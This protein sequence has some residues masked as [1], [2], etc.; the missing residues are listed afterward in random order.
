[1]TTT[2]FDVG[3][4]FAG[5]R[6]EEEIGRG[7]MG[8]V[9]RATE[10]SLER[11]VAL[12]LIT[13]ELA[14][15][16]DFRKR[17][18]RE[19]RIAAS[20]D[21]PHVLPVFAAGEADGQLYLAMRYVEGED[22]KTLLGREGVLS[23][24]HA[25]RI[26]SQIAEALD[27]AHRRGL[28]HRDLKPANVLLDTSGEAYLS[29]F[30]LTKQVGS[31]S[32]ETGRLVGTL[33]YLAP[34]QIRGEEVDARSDEYALACCFY[35]CLAGRAP[36][37]RPT[38]AELLWAHL[39][40][41]P[42]ALPGHPELDP[43][44]AR[45]L[46]KEKDERYESASAFCDAAG[47]ALGVE[48][49]RVRR[50]R[51]LLR[52]S[53]LLVAAGLLVLV[54]AAAA[55]GVEVTTGS[56]SPKP[57]GNAVAAI[58]VANGDVSSYTA[59]GATPSNVVTGG[60][61][62]WVLNADDRTISR[63]D[64]RTRRIVKT[65]ATGGVPTDLA[66]E[67][68]SL[69]VGNGSVASVGLASQGYTSSVVRIDPETYRVS[70]TVTLPYDHSVDPAYT[71]PL[72]RLSAYRGSVWAISPDQTVLR[73]DA[74]TARVVERVPV[75]F[76]NTIAAGKEGVWVTRNAS[77]VTRIDPRTGRVSQTIS[78][79]AAGFAG[80]AVGGGSVWAADPEDGTVW[81]IE[82]GPHPTTRTI[83]V[84]PGVT[85]IAFTE[86][87]VWAANFIEETVSHIDPR[88]NTVTS[89]TPVAGT[90]LGIAADR[91]VV[92][93]STAGARAGV[94]PAS[95]CGKVESGGKTPDLLIAS[96]FPLQG[97]GQHHVS[98]S[99]ADAIRFALR[100][101]GY[102]VGEYVVG[103]QSCDDST[104]QSVGSDYF[105]CASNAK[106]YSRTTQLVGLIGPYNSYCAEVQLPILNRA[107]S[108]SVP[109]ISSSNTDPGLTRAGPGVPRGEPESFYPT[110]VRNYLR[111]VPGD[112]LAGA[113]DAVF[114]K[115]LRLRKVYVLR[116][117]YVGYSSGFT[118]AARRIGLP[119][120]D[121]AVWAPQGGNA[122]QRRRQASI[123]SALARRVARSGADGV[124]LG[125]LGFNGGYAF[126]RALR[127]EV[128][129]KFPIIVTDAFFPVPQIMRDAGRPAALN[130]YVSFP[131]LGTLSP[132]G[133]R[134]WREFTMSEPGG[135][136]PNGTYAPQTLQAAELML[137]AIAR[138]DGTRASVLGEL[139]KLRAPDG[140]LG[141]YRFDANGDVTP[142]H[143]TIFK[144]TGRTP[145]SANL[146]S[147]FQGSVPVR[148]VSV[149][150]SLLGRKTAP[151]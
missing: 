55:I 38:E 35:E 13:P 113:A 115:Q 7:G 111:V 117:D 12:K 97:G 143:V 27:A 31:A 71:S 9:Y 122:K 60:G 36:F 114:A 138:S 151:R 98:R 65:F 150:T 3:W 93:T 130:T 64:P 14:S 34:E 49:P 75:H 81:R 41:A 123:D 132:S 32:T 82:P 84:G 112:D 144:I 136:V 118:R 72:S 50:R 63:I 126:L 24:D 2:Q 62:V 46:A 47:Q 52:R 8:V 133:R 134:L 25:L 135:T 149:P 18:L 42:S 78:V 77:D 33:D 29:D 100:R 61:S 91:D 69:W 51:R 101:H 110:G 90:P 104:A 102:R 45:A 37:H 124:F 109:V 121:S 68:G 56:S 23:P 16:A 92:W 103:Y 127:S 86:G 53:R 145:R 95:V 26:C 119:I 58:E 74:R 80:I 4:T 79:P 57:V 28:V 48:T 148:V 106:A 89:T 59:T 73:I 146:V 108:G 129:G 96:D 30:G 125:G 21:H 5:Y 87:E 70:A 11:P 85:F 88:S 66:F 140:V 17:F 105:K 128:G 99:M 20:L 120:T 39:Q 19:S 15:E 94:L 147:D 22:L 6:I 139:R 1:M 141:P 44:L 43:V 142:E 131:G 54:A 40:E 137:A 107:S 116:D 67:N 10:I 76:A 83:A